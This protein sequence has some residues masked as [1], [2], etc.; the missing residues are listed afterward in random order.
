VRVKLLE[1]FAAGIPVVATS[2]GAEGLTE[3]SGEIAWIADD[4][5]GFAAAVLRLLEDPA[6]AAALAARARQEVEQRWDMAVI[7][8]KL[9]GRY[10]EA[11]RE[12]RRAATSRQSGAR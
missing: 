10:R 5:E 4:P 1:A 7:T 8:R 11:V 2:I 6:A 12:K 3:K 9:E